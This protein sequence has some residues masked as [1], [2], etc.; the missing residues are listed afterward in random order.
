M[1][2]EVSLYNHEKEFDYNQKKVKF[3]QHTKSNGLNWFFSSNCNVCIVHDLQSNPKTVLRILLFR[4][5]R[6]TMGTKQKI[7]PLRLSYGPSKLSRL[8]LFS[9]LLQQRNISSSN[10]VNSCQHSLS[11]ANL[12]HFIQN[13][14]MI[15]IVLKKSPKAFFIWNFFISNK[16]ISANL[17]FPLRFEMQD[18]TMSTILIYFYDNNNNHWKLEVCNLDIFKTDALV[19]MEFKTIKEMLDGNKCQ[20]SN[21]MFKFM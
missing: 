15:E 14:R 9:L 1:N 18:K 8:T 7:V 11:A 10:T 20:I 2:S 21:L 17:W 13:I 4:K 3:F 12:N 19:L 5:P 6:S 16:F